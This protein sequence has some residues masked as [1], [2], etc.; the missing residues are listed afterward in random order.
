MG[1]YL[2]GTAVT[3]VERFWTVDP[4]TQV[5]TLADPT[6]I[7][8]TVQAPEGTET[9]YEN[10]VHPEVTHASTGVSLCDLSPPLPAGMWTYRCDGTGAVEASA[11]GTFTVLESGVLD[12]T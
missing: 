6:G 1:V 2:R 8:F 3:I 9:Q 4:V 11:E 12:P 5:A 10:G 7:V